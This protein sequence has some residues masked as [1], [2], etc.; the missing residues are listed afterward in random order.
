[1]LVGSLEQGSHCLS[2]YLQPG[3]R[4]GRLLFMQDGRMRAVISIT[5]TVCAIDEENLNLEPTT[6]SP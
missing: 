4:K 5:C 6:K 3:A 1:M 2:T